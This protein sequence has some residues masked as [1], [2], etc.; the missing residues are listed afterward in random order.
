MSSSES[1]EFEVIDQLEATLTTEELT[2]VQAWLRPT[3]YAAPSSEYHRHLSSQA[4]GTGLWICETSKYKQWQESNDHGSLWIKG[5]PGAGKSVTAA[6]MIQHM[7]SDGTPVLYFFFRYIISANRR[8]RSLVRDFLAQLL[9]YSVRLQAMLQPLISNPLDDFSDEILWEYLL[10]GLSSIPK[11]YCVVDALDEMELLP[12][13][14]FLDRLNNLATFRPDAVKLLMTSRPKQY[15]QSSLR[16]ASIVHISL[17]DDL[18]GKDIALFLSYRLQILLPQDDTHVLRNSLVSA[19]SERSDGLFLYARLL[20]DQIIPTLGSTRLDIEEMVKTLPVGLEEMYNSMLFQQAASLGIDTQIQVFL[21]QLAT[22]SS[23]TLRLNEMASVLASTFPA[24]MIP[25]T[26]KIV[27]RSACAPL[28]EILEDETVSVIHHSFTEFLLDGERT[29][30][31]MNTNDPQFPVL[32]TEKVHKRLSIICIDYLRAGGLRVYNDNSHTKT[33][34]VFA[35]DDELY[36]Y[37]DKD[38]E[39]DGYNYQEAKLR[40]PYLEYAVGN[41][42]FHASKYDVEDE[43]FFKSIAGFLD[44]ESQDFKKWLE[45]EW[46]KGLKPSE[47]QAPTPLH[48]AAFAGLTTFAEKL[49]EGETPVDPRD[50]EDRTPLHWACARGHIAMAALLLEHGATPDPEDT[51]GV[52]PIHEAARKNHAAIVKMLL[53]AGVDPL[54]PKTKENVKRYLRCG[55]VSTKGE[56]AVEYAW[57]QGHTDTIMTMLPF[58]KP[59]TV[60]ELFCQCCRYG[61]FEAVRGILKATD[62]SPNSTYSGATALYLAC[63]AHSVGIVE[64]LLAQGADVNQTS[65]WK[66]TNRNACGG[67]SRQEPMRLP[68]HGVVMGWK[69]SNNLASQQ[70]LRLLIASGADIEA[71]DQDGDTTLLSLFTYHDNEEADIV[72]VSGILQAGANVLAVDEN[73]VGVLS[74]FLQ[75]SQNIQILKLLLE[76]GVRAD[77]IGK[78]GDTALHT[79]VKSYYSRQGK[80][81]SLADIINLLLEKGARCDLKNKDGLTALEYAIGNHECDPKTFTMLL[82]ACTNAE[83]I[84]RCMWSLSTWKE[85]KDNPEYIRLLQTFD[86]SLEDR[87]SDGMTVLLASTKSEELFK[88][89]LECGSDVKAVDLKGRGVLHHYVSGAAYGQPHECLRRLKEMV[90]MGLDP[91]QVSSPKSQWTRNSVES[92][93]TKV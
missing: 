27:A 8:P 57:L 28:L 47:I 70:I 73:G 56:T 39:T 16:E 45:L 4:P 64:L 71:K 24:S 63:R 6:S 52:K 38:K 29:K 42:A 22:H 77:V 89:F 68:I 79:A 92:K 53:E 20:L 55:D 14:G 78:D 75:G 62:V 82:R 17:E 87:D 44:S 11:G 67:H 21:L 76:Y 88:A 5:V 7:K 85:K 48:V 46:M 10:T 25:D 90:E 35:T 2:K 40:Y 86:V 32:S 51:R 58:L 31:K 61:K 54:T 26:P 50:A 41:W 74:R 84:K 23:R 43:D 34:T 59:E 81:A 19:I 65:E 3:D 36:S 60:E 1:D 18:V 80:G 9:P 13:D 49:L 69:T 66:V 12:K 83:T 33:R 15:L 72:V 91:L 93:L 30:V 37:F